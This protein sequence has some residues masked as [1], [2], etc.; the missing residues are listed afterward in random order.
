MKTDD[1][2]SEDEVETLCAAHAEGADPYARRREAFVYLALLGLRRAELAGLR[3][4]AI[5]LDAEKPTLSVRA[6]RV[7]TANGIVEHARSRGAKIGRP[8]SL[9]AADQR[10]AKMLFG[11]GSSAEEI[12]ASLRRCAA[13][14]APCTARWQPN[15]PRCGSLSAMVPIRSFAQ[16]VSA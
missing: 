10:H 15:V 9:S 3:W 8:R 11:G 14:S 7:S 2:L 13:A 12:A 5:D 16:A 4:N 1:A 6:T